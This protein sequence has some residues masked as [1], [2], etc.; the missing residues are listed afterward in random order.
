MSPAVDLATPNGE[1]PLWGMASDDLNATLLAWRPG[2]GTPD[3]VNEERDVLV[4]VLGG[5][6]SVTIDGSTTGVTAQQAVLVPKGASRAI[7]AGPD[8]I[9]YLTVHLRRH[10]LQLGRFAGS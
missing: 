7:S 1:G 3:H 6:G 4:V 2:G 9:R 5:S 10:G 8:G